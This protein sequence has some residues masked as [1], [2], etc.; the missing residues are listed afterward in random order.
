MYSLESISSQ[1]IRSAQERIKDIAIRT[2]LIRLNVD[3]T[4]IAL[5]VNGKGEILLAHHP[6]ALDLEKTKI[7]IV[8]LS[9]MI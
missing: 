8:K 1:M 3:D 6:D 4:P 5:L 2:P 9:E 7:F